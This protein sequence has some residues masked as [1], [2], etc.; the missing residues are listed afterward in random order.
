MTSPVNENTWTAP[1]IELINPLP[2]AL[3]HYQAS[4]ISVL[5]QLGVDV[6]VRDAPST[7]ISGLSR[8]QKLRRVAATVASRWRTR[9]VEHPIVILW[10]AF[11]N[12]DQFTWPASAGRRLVILHD[13]LPLRKSFA[14]GNVS[15]RLAAGFATRVKTVAHSDRAVADLELLGRRVH[16]QV[17]HPFLERST[18]SGVQVARRVLVAGQFKEA[19]DLELMTSLGPFLRERGYLPRIVG[20][21]WPNV[22]G[23]DVDARF[24]SEEELDLELAAAEVLLLPYRRVYQSGIAIRAAELGTPTVG[25]VASNVSDIFGQDWAGLLQDNA[26]PLLWAQA[27]DEVNRIEPDAK[28][29]RILRWKREVISSWR[30]FAESEGWLVPGRRK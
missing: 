18:P 16:A 13:P 30:S 23:W 28:T 4:M 19:R 22:P 14:S 25:F 24:V 1:R 21:G 12:L 7:E 2:L 6:I 20:R 9:T 17:P 8:A 11:G 10:P 29:A 26:T 27:I 3:D 5:E 15:A